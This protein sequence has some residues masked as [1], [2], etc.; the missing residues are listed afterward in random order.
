MPTWKSFIYTA[1]VVDA[2]S[3]KILGWHVAASMKTGLV[4]DALEQA[5][6][7]QGDTVGTMHHSDLGVQ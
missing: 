2:F 1:F 4:L 3:G 6:H 5:V 7:E